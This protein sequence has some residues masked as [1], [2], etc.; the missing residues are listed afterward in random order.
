MKIQ[1]AAVLIT[2]ASAGI[3]AALA[4][5]LGRRGA[6]LAVTGRDAGRLEAVRAEFALAGDLCEEAFRTRLF[7]EAEEALGG[8]DILVNNAGVG[9]YAPPAASNL[10][11]VRAMFELNFFAA[12]DLAQRAAVAMRER[13]RG[14]IV[15][16]SSIAGRVTLPWFTLYSASK[17]ALTAFTEG[18]RAELAGTGVEAMVVSPG[19]V[20]TGF[21]GNVLDG[22]PP[23]ALKRARRFATTPEACARAIADGIEQSRKEIVTPF[24][25]QALVWAARL[26]PGL[27]AWQLER[28]NRDLGSAP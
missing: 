9:L 21:Q 3:G 24:S 5:E 1:G 8:V 27:I 11:L 18:L 6:R 15:N 7:A 4:A 28:M 10:G 17:F 16:I 2:G 13:G 14:A 12:V 25:G 20:R 19:Y 22:D 26:W 23:E